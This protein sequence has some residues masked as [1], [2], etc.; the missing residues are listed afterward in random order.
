MRVLLAKLG[1][2]AIACDETNR[3]KLRHFLKSI[4]PCCLYGVNTVR[5]ELGLVPLEYF[6][7]TSPDSSDTLNDMLVFQMLDMLLDGTGIYLEFLAKF[8]S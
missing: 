7:L 3:L 4:I 5:L 6:P 1:K 8:F 2:Q